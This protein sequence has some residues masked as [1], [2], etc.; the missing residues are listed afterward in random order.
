MRWSVPS[1]RVRTV[2]DRGILL[3]AAR[4]RVVDVVFDGHRVWSFW[5]RRDTQPAPGL[6]RLAAWP[7]P[8][9]KHLNGQSLVTV[10]D[11]ATGQV[12]FEAP[13]SLGEGTAPIRFL[14]KAG[15]E[16]GID[17]SGRLVPTFATRTSAD[18]DSLMDAVETVIGALRHTGAQP[19]LAYG[20]LLGAVREGTVLGHDS[21]AD[22]GYVSAFS[23]PVDVMR[24][25]FRIQREIN[26]RGWQTH[27][28]S[29]GAFKID[30]REG[31][32]VRG[33]DVFGGF[34]DHDRLYLMGEVGVP[35][36]SDWLYPLR[37]CRM[38]GRELPVPARPEK[39]LEAMYGEGW[40]VPDPA[41]KFSTPPRTVRALDDW[42]RGTR[43][44][45][46]YWQRRA[47][48]LGAKPPPRR[49]SELARL[50][51]AD[52]GTLGAEVLD[53][54]AGR[55]GD[56]LWLARRGHRVTAF[57]YA[58]RGMAAAVAQAT[59]EGVH[60]EPRM[61]SLTEYRSVFGE[62]AR[63]ANRSAPRVVLA[64]HVLDAT[65]PFGRRSLARLCSM[66]LREGGRVHAEF[67]TAASA[68]DVAWAAGVADP[69]K[70]TKLFRTV[71]ATRVDIDQV[72]SDGRDHPVH[73]IV[74]EW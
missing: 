5:V 21:D 46:Q 4:D 6:S 8:M 55:G 63:L 62:G 24:E 74:A 12:F 56:S 22:V 42:F 41:F 71:G 60:L 69:D 17:K 32:V 58:P 2:D 20:T 28:Y 35:F 61:L 31:D 33:L 72:T 66:A 49:P 47:S 57:D 53:I 43:P 10:R 54:G 44:Q 23:C 38:E 14:N 13:V 9:R 16:L 59:A 37:T 64:R 45:I 39:L 36:Q 51:A 15:V 29:G 40:A 68:R 34:L 25:S 70:V 3:R 18:V 73:R 50:V 7:R 30:V 26:A 11:S 67:H 48:V 19:F 27:R 1:V 52:A 65:S